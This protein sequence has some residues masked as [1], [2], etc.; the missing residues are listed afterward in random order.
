MAGVAFKGDTNDTRFI[1]A[2]HIKERLQKIGFTVELSDPYVKSSE[3]DIISDLFEATKG[4][5]ILVL[6]TDHSQ[7]LQL[8]L[9]KLK[10]T[11]DDKPLIID[12]GGF[13][14]KSRAIDL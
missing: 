11:M 12:T 2:F 10:A 9:S 14:H 8:D 6:L 4:M 7:Y 3:D 13:I 5:E 1:T